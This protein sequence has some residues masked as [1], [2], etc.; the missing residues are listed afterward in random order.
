MKGMQGEGR[1]QQTGQDLTWIREENLMPPLRTH[2]VDIIN[3][4]TCGK[5]DDELRRLVVDNLVTYNTR[6][7]NEFLSRT[8]FEIEI[9][10]TGS[11]EKNQTDLRSEGKKLYLVGILLSSITSPI[12]RFP[13]PLL[14]TIFLD[15]TLTTMRAG[16]RRPTRTS[17]ERASAS[18][19]VALKSP[20]RRC[21]GR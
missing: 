7:L 4:S 17:S 9:L 3:A 10:K 2:L 15:R 20:V 5:V 21:L 13:S 19:I 11:N 16:F 14:R 1:R 8:T 6:Q 18:V 12:S